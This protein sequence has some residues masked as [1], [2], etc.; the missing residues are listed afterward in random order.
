MQHF[1]VPWVQGHQSTRY[2]TEKIGYTEGE[3]D[4][5][6]ENRTTTKFGQSVQPSKWRQQAK[7]GGVNVLANEWKLSIPK[8]THAK[9]RQ[10][11][12]LRHLIP[13]TTCGKLKYTTTQIQPKSTPTIST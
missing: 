3:M 2:Y 9:Q 12:V 11:Q 6:D 4:A 10:G 8:H 7:Q 5:K 13:T 1:Q